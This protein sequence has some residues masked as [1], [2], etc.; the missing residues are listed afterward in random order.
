MSDIDDKVYAGAP[1][2]NCG[3]IYKYKS[4]NSC[5][6]CVR[7]HSSAW[8]KNPANKELKRE[9]A[10]RY[11][12]ENPDKALASKKRWEL[13]N[14]EKSLA[15]ARRRAGLPIPTRP[16]PE[17]CE[18]CHKPSHDGKALALDHCKESGIFRG[19]LCMNC[20]TSI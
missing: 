5:V 1:C 18:K 7:R 9:A 4:G 17:T 13:N 11:R 12:S 16:C 6:I 3:T 8:H 15:A 19:W 2:K 10:K 20:N 14:P